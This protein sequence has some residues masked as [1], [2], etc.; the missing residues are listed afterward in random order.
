MRRR[1]PIPQRPSPAPRPHLR[2]PHPRRLHHALSR[3]DYGGAA[4]TAARLGQPELGGKDW[5]VD[6]AAGDLRGLLGQLD[7]DTE[8]YRSVVAAQLSA[9]EVSLHDKLAAARQ[10]PLRRDELL[11][12]YA[13]S[14]G[15]VLKQLFDTHIGTQQAMGRLEDLDDLHDVRVLDAVSGSLL[16]ILPLYPPAVLPATLLGAGKAAV[17]PFLYAGATD[18]PQAEA[19]RSAAIR[20]VDQWYSATLGHMIVEMQDGGGFAGTPAEAERWQREHGVAAG[21]PSPTRRAGCSRR[22]G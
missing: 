8:A 12:A 16:T 21:D 2:R 6:F 3:T 22:T 13:R 15:L 7:H 11:Q 1:P 5:G 18:N 20:Q 17:L 9:S 4:R 10:D 14:H 19:N